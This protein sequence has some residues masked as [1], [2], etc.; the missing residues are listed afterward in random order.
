M[1]LE[2]IL[3]SDYKRVQPLEK[4][5]F[6]NIESYSVADKLFKKIVKIIEILTE[7]ET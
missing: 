5:S 6:D 7:K 2:I 1:R 4:Y 3:Y